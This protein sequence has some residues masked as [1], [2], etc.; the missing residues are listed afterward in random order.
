MSQNQQLMTCSPT[1][2]S[3]RTTT[4]QKLPQRSYWTRQGQSLQHVQALHPSRPTKQRRGRIALAE[5]L[6]QWAG[7]H[8]TIDKDEPTRP[9]AIAYM[10]RICSSLVLAAH[11]LGIN[12]LRFTV[13]TMAD[14][15]PSPSLSI[16]N[17]IV[18]EEA[19]QAEAVT[20]QPDASAKAAHG[21][22]AAL[23]L[24]EE[25]GGLRQPVDPEASKKLLRKIDLHIMPLICIVYFLQYIDK[26]AISYASVT[27]IIQD[28]GLH[29][30]Q[31]NWVASI[32]FFG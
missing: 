8:G 11:C 26:T 28:T 16:S 15:S 30:N 5:E 27:G 21:A 32:F 14:P 10:W 12:R 20:T 24:L 19:K 31:F 6:L 13:C 23:R 29:G 3:R 9:T 18:S 25:T 4:E 2:I 22:D 7:S 1:T 17:N